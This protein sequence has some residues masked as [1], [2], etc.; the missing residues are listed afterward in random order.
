MGG[1][2]G[3]CGAIVSAMGGDEGGRRNNYITALYP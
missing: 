3:G 2:M 1:A